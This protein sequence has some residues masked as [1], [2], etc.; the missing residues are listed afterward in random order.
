MIL[1]Q[2]YTSEVGLSDFAPNLK[3]VGISTIIFSTF[4]RKNNI[5]SSID[6]TEVHR[7]G[8]RCTRFY[9]V[10]ESRLIDREDDVLDVIL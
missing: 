7:Q 1:F 4:C 9:S 5:K 6:N 2:S 8:R 3:N 10:I